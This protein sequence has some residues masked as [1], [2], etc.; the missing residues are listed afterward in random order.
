MLRFVCCPAAPKTLAFVKRTGFAS[1]TLEEPPS[2][3]PL[4]IYGAGKDNYAKYG[5]LDHEFPRE[6]FDF[7]NPDDIKR[8]W[9]ARM[10]TQ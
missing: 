1:G 2:R 6:A 8:C 9:S 3:P 7:D 10:C 4:P 5:E